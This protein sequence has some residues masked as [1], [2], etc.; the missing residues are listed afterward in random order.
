MNFKKK[1]MITNTLYD[2]D[3]M[4][5]NSFQPPKF[6][7]GV[8]EGY[9]TSKKFRSTVKNRLYNYYKDNGLL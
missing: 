3:V 2:D 9:M 8:P 5:E 4:V 7:D 1:V 6:V